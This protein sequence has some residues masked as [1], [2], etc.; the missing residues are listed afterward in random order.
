MDTKAELRRL[1]E[2]LDGDKAEEALEYLKWIIDNRR[3]LSEQDMARILDADR[4]LS[5]S[6][7][8]L[9]KVIWRPED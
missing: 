3:Q 4:Q 7:S 5:A 1:V 2:R 6:G 8:V 9:T